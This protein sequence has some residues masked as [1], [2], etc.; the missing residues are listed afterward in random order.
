[1]VGA[2]RNGSAKLLLAEENNANFPTHIHGEI[3]VIYVIRGG[4]KAFCDGTQYTLAN[5]SIFVSFPEQ[6]HGYSEC[7]PGEYLLLNINPSRLLHLEHLFRDQIPLT[8]L[9]QGTGEILQPLFE[10][11]KEFK[12][13]GDSCVVE[14]YLTAFFG[15]LLRTMVF[16]RSA[17]MK[18]TISQI[19]H[20]CSQNY[21][22][23]ITIP[24]LC[25][26]LH[27]SQS[28]ISHIFSQQLKISFPDY[29]NALRLN[30]AI[31]LLRDPKLSITQIVE[32]AGFPTIR[33]FN[34]VFRKQFGCSPTAYRARLSIE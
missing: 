34:R 9:S 18:K 19:L 10:A 26:A 1:M 30:R 8:A 5:G 3:E 14:G 21:R 28:H 6:I 12:A 22:E 2:I 13:H 24:D 25:R 32:R 20:Y 7:V 4:G 31:L 33:T 15:R 17:D 11:L 16:Q 23:A 27:V 29:M